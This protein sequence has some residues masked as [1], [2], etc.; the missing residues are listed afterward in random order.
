MEID[1][2]IAVERMHRFPLLQKD[3]RDETGQERRLKQSKG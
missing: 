2:Y 1:L 3:F